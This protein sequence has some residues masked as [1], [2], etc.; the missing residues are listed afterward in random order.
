LLQARLP[1]AYVMLSAGLAVDPSCRELRTNR[2]R[3]GRADVA[4]VIPGDE[5]P[6]VHP[7]R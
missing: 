2:L 6:T 7:Y 4:Q 5:P 1:E 3:P